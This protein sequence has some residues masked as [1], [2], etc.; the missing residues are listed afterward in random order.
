[1]KT[2]DLKINFRYLGGNIACLSVDSI[3]GES[4]HNDINNEEAIII[5]NSIV[6][7]KE[8]CQTVKT[9]LKENQELKKHLK[10]P[11]TCN[12]KT[13]EDYKSY[14]EDTTREQI[15]EDTYIEYCAYVNLAHRYSELK[16]QLENCYC[17]RTDC[18][19]RIKDSKA[20]DSL[21]QKVKTQQKEFISYLEKEIKRIN[22]NDLYIGELNLRL[23]DIKF[24]QYLIYKEILQKYKSIIGV[25]D[26]TNK[27]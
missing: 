13:L 3:D 1:M 26:E 9:L 21:V 18:S 6:G 19:G 20:Y 4:V 17:N 23:D 25:S 27:Q 14:Y 16:E 10:V 24:T 8:N 22:P 5:F 15:L 2:K 11:K 12:L 7:E